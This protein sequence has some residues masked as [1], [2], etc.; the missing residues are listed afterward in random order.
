M[1]ASSPGFGVSQEES[2]L[3]VP[4]PLDEVLSNTNRHRQRKSGI[5][6][7][8]VVVQLETSHLKMRGMC[9]H[10]CTTTQI[11]GSEEDTE[12]SS[13]EPKAVFLTSLVER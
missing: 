3:V 1:A 7:E 2:T 4:L 8:I 11:Q 9:R 10:W 12:E 6:P 5:P 13:R